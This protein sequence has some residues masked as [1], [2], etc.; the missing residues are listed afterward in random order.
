[1]DAP[2]LDQETVERLLDGSSGDAPAAPGGLVR[3]L[4][5]VRAGPRPG[6]LDGEAAAVAEFRAAR[7]TAALGGRQ[8]FADS[9]R[10]P[11][12][13]AGDH[14]DDRPARRFATL[15][16]AKVALAT[17]AA[18]LTGGVALATVTG[19]L[20]GAGRGEA[21]PPHRDASAAPST[22]GSTPTIRPTRP[23]TGPTAGLPDPTSPAGLCAAYRAVGEVER[24]RALQAPPFAGLV[25][26]AGGP[27]RVP[28]YCAGLL[29]AAGSPGPTGPP[30][31]TGPTG[32]PGATPTRDV[33]D[34]DTGR[35]PAGTAAPTSG[36]A[37][38]TPGAARTPGDPASGVRRTPAGRG[39]GTVRPPSG[40]EP[41]PDRSATGRHDD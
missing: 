16:G 37:A 1:M 28:G 36:A 2:R 38:P 24:G 20:P 14:A 29:D 34:P 19:N 25:A 23:A 13:G 4:D 5:A 35:P 9:A 6:E 7:A 11:P 30:S 40:D 10:R 17:A 12:V 39:S 32:P 8:T 31:G 22:T 3:C 27:E 21:P 18:T 15:L 33:P 41:D 26:A